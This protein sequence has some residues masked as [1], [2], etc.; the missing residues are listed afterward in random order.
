MKRIPADIR[1]IF[2]LPAFAMLTAGAVLVTPTPA[3]SQIVQLVEVDVKVLGQGFRASE[4][5]GENVY[6]D[7][8]E[9]IGTIDDVIID[10]ERVLFAVLQVGGFLGIGGRLIA[11]SPESLAIEH[12]GSKLKI[13]LVGGSREALEKSKEFKYPEK[14]ED[15]SQDKSQQPSK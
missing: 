13:K 14:S 3:L 4:L 15:K 11:V 8:N 1:P 6:N 5:M 12:D 7:K 9:N 2:L 10:K